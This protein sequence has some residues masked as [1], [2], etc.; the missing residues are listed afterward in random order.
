MTAGTQ[1][2][3]TLKS[4]SPPAYIVGMGRFLPNAPVG[5][6]EMEGILGQ[7]GERASRARRITL[8]NSGIL[9]R[10]YAIDR[11]TGRPTHTNAQ[12]TAAAVRDA[13]A[14]VGWRV[15][16]LGL[17]ACGTS[18]PDQIMPAHAQMVHGELGGAPLEAVSVAGVCSAGMGALKHAWLSVRA[19]DCS[20]AVACGSELVSSFMA[21]RNFT[22]E[23]PDSAGGTA[24]APA[25]A[26]EK[27]FLRWMLSDGAGAALVAGEPVAGRTALRIDWID[28]LSLAHE[29]PVCM[30]SG[31]V[32]RQDGT[33][34]G[35]RNADSPEAMVRAD[36]L[37]IKQDARLLDAKITRLFARDTLLAIA[38]RHGAAA[39]DYDWFLPHYSSEYFRGVLMDGLAALDFR[40]PESR[41]FTNLRQVGNV[42]SASIFLML[43]ELLNGSRF[44]PGQKILCFVPESARFTVYYMQ[45]TVI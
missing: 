39:R 36:Y 27:D 42:G 15:G 23:E 31:A 13:L 28:G 25:L 1:A 45:L 18:T 37:A 33:L 21:A 11:A 43:E 35:W 26:F 38:A 32:K 2:T 3:S 14:R 7:V 12:L 20:R 4:L 16:D 24:V 22:H 5:N 10:H 6:D 29:L 9:S 44:R 17:L 30:Y 19:G 40:I 41:W 8:R 34:R